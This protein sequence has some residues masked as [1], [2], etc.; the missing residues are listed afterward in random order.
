LLGSVQSTSDRHCTHRSS[1]L[2]QRLAGWPAQSLGSAQVSAQVDS[3]LLQLWLLAQSSAERHSAQTLPT[4]AGLPRPQ[5]VS[6]RHSRQAPP[7]QN[8]RSGGQS[9]AEL[10]STLVPSTPGN[11]SSV[12]PS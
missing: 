5:S 6:T 4:H 9:S 12:R 1:S 10:H 2:E 3:T 8:A 11:S 7:A